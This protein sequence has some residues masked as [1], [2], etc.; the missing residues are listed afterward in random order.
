MKIERFVQE[1]NTYLSLESMLEKNSVVAYIADLKHFL[2]FYYLQKND[3][4]GKSKLDVLLLSRN[5]NNIDGLDINIEN[6]IENEKDIDDIK[7]NE[8]SINEFIQDINLS[9][10]EISNVK[11]EIIIEYMALMRE[12]NFK[13]KTI[14]RKLASLSAYYNF[15]LE[16]KECTNNPIKLITQPKIG[17]KLPTILSIQEI[18]AILNEIDM[19]TPYG[20]R[21]CTM[22]ELLYA[23]GVRVSELCSIEIDKIDFAQ[24]IIR[25]IGKGNKERF[26]PFHAA[27]KDRLSDYL[28]IRKRDLIKDKPDNGILFLNYKGEQLT[29]QYCW[30]M[31]KEICEAARIK[32]NVSPHTFRHSFATHLLS[33][34]ADL[35]SIQSF[36]GHT[37]ITVTEIYTHVSDNMKKFTVEHYHPRFR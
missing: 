18:D 35:H 6:D 11:P 9:K 28:L 26:V 22:I 2:Y 32:K 33:G 4:I 17:T 24:M 31:I 20:Y 29:R 7:S 21:N 14:L 15:L 30:K 1:F 13:V 16:E 36:L 5:V 19:T 12:S 10:K 8:V 37:S 27:I 23:S 3:L 34:G 25:V